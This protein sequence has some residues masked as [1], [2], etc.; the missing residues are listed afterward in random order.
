MDPK[1][2]SNFFNN[3]IL[4]LMDYDTNYF[5]KFRKYFLRS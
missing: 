5:D 3:Q 4:A 1:E 2:E